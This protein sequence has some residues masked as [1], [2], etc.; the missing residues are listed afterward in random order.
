MLLSLVFLSSLATRV[1]V[2]L[3]QLIALLI[4]LLLLIAQLIALLI[5]LLLLLIQLRLTALRHNLSDKQKSL[6]LFSTRWKAAFFL[7]PSP[8]LSR[9]TTLTQTSRITQFFCLIS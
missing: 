3:L 6:R 2:L 1:L 4:L 5:A 7:S 8:H 9:I